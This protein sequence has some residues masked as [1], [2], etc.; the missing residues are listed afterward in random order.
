MLVLKNAPKAVVFFMLV[1]VSISVAIGD[2]IAM[3][4]KALEERLTFLENELNQKQVNID[5]IWTMIAACLV[6]FMQG[7][8]LLLEAGLVRSKNSIN[9]AQKNIADFILA[10]VCFGA[11]GFMLMFGSSFGG[12]I[13]LDWELLAFDQVE[14]W[15]FTFFVFQVVFCGTAA[16]IVSGAVAER[17][18]FGGYLSVTLLIAL[19]IYPVYGHWA[20]GNL[21]NSDNEPFLA[22]MG[23]VDFAGSTVVHSIGG[24]VALAAVLVIGPRLG[25]YDQSGKPVEINGHSPV[26]ATFGCI[27]LWIGWIG[28]NGGSTTAGTP[29][30]AHIIANT[31]VAGAIGGLFGLVLGRR[32]DGHYRPDRSINGVLGGLVGI[33]AGCDVVTMWGAVVIGAG[34]AVVVVLAADFL[35]KKLKADDVVGAVSVHGVA[36]AFGT[37]ALAV[38]APA[39]TFEMGMWAQLGVQAI[40][41]GTAFVWAFVLPY[42]ILKV[43]NNMFDGGMRVS[44]QDEL[45]GL[46]FAEHAATMGASHVLREMEHV[47]AGSQGEE[48][49]HANFI[50]ADEAD[51]IAFY[52]KR[53]MDRNA[54]LVTGMKS[55]TEVLVSASQNLA[56]MSTELSAQAEQTQSRAFEL[57]STT[58][59]VSGDMDRMAGGV[60]EAGQLAQSIAQNADEMSATVQSV[61]NEIRAVVGSIDEISS[62]TGQTQTLLSNAVGEV[63]DGRDKM[64]ALGEAASSTG[65]VLNLISDIANQTNMLALNATIEAARSGE[66]GK[67]FAVVAGEVKKLA[68]QT[69]RA[70]ADIEQRVSTMQSGANDAVNVMEKIAGL[71]EN[72]NETADGINMAVG[73][74]T[75]AANRISGRLNDMTD[76]T[77]HVA[78]EINRVAQNTHEASGM[79][80]VAAN[81]TGNLNE[82]ILDVK[83][84]ASLSHTQARDLKGEAEEISKSAAELNKLVG[85][86]SLHKMAQEAAE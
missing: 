51:E 42:I 2:A 7:G 25:R 57:E 75:T 18:K 86:L 79:A 49:P 48:E 27:I 21:L 29:A 83:Q 54:S 28:F 78:S 58:Q 12:L 60:G 4:A 39:G 5:H 15:T 80:G 56:S 26:L 72:V 36:G 38:V 82:G 85:S 63:R 61:A 34:S 8:F 53:L 24:W 62:S 17:M 41:V 70:I 11:V 84:A 6:F 33:T 55:T 66:A 3:D 52:F 10:T 22:A 19:L 30:F 23:F 37:L 1:A 81:Q 20:W 74:Q 67:G 68:D 65:A 44:E 35:E 43:I 69:A 32:V 76:M 16:T 14:D 9:V 64:K 45:N 40:G 46:N 77:S 50:A 71:V 31:V 73:R 59:S 13:G 47:F